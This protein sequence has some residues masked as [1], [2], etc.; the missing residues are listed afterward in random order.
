[1]GYIYHINRLAGFLNHQPGTGYVPTRW[2]QKLPKLAVF[3][4][5]KTGESLRERFEHPLTVVTIEEE[6]VGN[7]PGAWVMYI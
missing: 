1:M 7:S 3:L 4:K 6:R 5:L 2:C